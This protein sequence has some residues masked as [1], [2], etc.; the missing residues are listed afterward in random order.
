MRT[1]S[2]AFCS[3]SLN[4]DNP[5][6]K[7]KI[8]DA[9]VGKLKTKQPPTTPNNPF[10]SVFRPFRQRFRRLVPMNMDSPGS[11]PGQ[12]QVKSGMTE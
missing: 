9:I 8:E 7:R 12:A 5:L 10:R 1:L 6:E 3:I 2:T 4:V 11:S